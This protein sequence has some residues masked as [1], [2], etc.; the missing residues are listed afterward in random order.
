MVKELSKQINFKIVLNNENKKNLK[1]LIS[2]IFVTYVNIL[3][4]GKLKISNL[5]GDDKLLLEQNINDNKKNV[6]LPRKLNIDEYNYHKKITLIYKSLEI[7][8]YVSSKKSTQLE[9]YIKQIINLMIYAMDINFTHTKLNSIIYFV[10]LYESPKTLDTS[11]KR[12]II[13]PDEIN[14]GS[15]WASGFKPIN[16]WRTE[17]LVKV[18]IHEL[19]HCLKFDIK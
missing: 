10:M 16:V 6:F 14:S 11:K 13:T 1:N 3:N 8:T 7:T 18:G 19:I 5:N 17:E 12:K 15:T 9:K 2:Y 4:Y